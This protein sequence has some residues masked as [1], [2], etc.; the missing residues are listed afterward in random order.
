M[1]LSIHQWHQRYQQQAR[2]TQNLRKY[3][4]ERV[5]IRTAKRILDV[6]CGTG[7][8]LGELR[9]ISS[10]SL[11]GLDIDF[12]SISIVQQ[13]ILKSILTHGDALRLPFHSGSFDVSLCHFLL[14]WV[15]NPLQVLHE[16]RRVTHD[17][18][19]ILAL[20]EPDYGGRIDFPDKLSQIGHWQIEALIN[21]GANPVIGRELR[22][23]FSE[24]GLKNIEVGVLGGQW[25]EEWGDDDF[26]LEWEV[27]L[28]DLHNKNEFM[29]SA[30]EYKSL[31]LDSREKHQR[32]LYV[33]T[34]YALGEV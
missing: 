16:M 22:S 24:C 11:F 32:I 10:G 23:L 15:K 2:W 25:G 26:E 17:G 8:L 33:P 18:G 30:N 34:F 3:V 1:T 31:E 21:Q 14:L 28:S 19:Y 9:R 20:A 5:D 6:G 13:S 7:V 4:Y 12:N 27:I 29:E